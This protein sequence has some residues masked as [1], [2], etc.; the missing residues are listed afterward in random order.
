MT[1]NIKT[2]YSR[3]AGLAASAQAA[4]AA[5]AGPSDEMVLAA[6]RVLSPG[7]FRHGLDPQPKDGPHTTSRMRKEAELCRRMLEAALVA[8]PTLQPSPTAQ[9]DVPESEYRRGYRHGYEQRDAEVR[10]ALA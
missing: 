2:D 10:G 3:R 4:P 8:A 1:R 7:L 5:V 9:V 6:A